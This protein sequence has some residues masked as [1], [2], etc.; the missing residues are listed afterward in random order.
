MIWGCPFF[1]GTSG[2]STKHLRRMK[3]V[4]LPALCPITGPAAAA[5]PCQGWQN[6]LH[7][8][9]PLGPELLPL[10]GRMFISSRLELGRG[11][12]PFA[13]VTD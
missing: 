9:G 5:Q 13:E 6:Q 1:G 11:V 4:S 10:W 2:P 3:N 12:R 8:T 7:S